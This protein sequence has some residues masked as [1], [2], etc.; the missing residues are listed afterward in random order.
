MEIQEIRY[1]STVPKKM[2]PKL[3]YRI[4]DTDLSFRAVLF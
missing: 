2:V 3:N 4:S 1:Q